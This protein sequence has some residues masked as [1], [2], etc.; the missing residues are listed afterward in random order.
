MGPKRNKS[1]DTICSPA[2][3]SAKAIQRK[4]RNK[5]VSSDK[6]LR[7]RRAHYSVCNRNMS[8]RKAAKEYSLSYGFLYRRYSG[9]V[10]INKIKGPATIFTKSEDESM[11]LWLSDMAHMGL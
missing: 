8:L 2:K 4:Y 3:K 5:R 11:T 9:E 1:V 10:D 6:M 7:V